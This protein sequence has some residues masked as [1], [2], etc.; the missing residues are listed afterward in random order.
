M[1]FLPRTIAVYLP[2]GS[3]AMIADSLGLRRSMPAVL[4]IHD[5][6]LGDNPADDR[7]LP[8]IIIGNHSTSA[9][10]QFQGRISQYVLNAVPSE[11]RA[12]GAHD[13]PLCS[14]PLDNEPSDHYVIARQNNAAT[15]DVA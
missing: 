12:N 9:V 8:V 7:S 10:V 11:L 6:V 5:L 1:M 13:H 14:A 15:A 4:N 3:S 2:G